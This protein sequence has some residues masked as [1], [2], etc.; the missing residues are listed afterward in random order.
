MARKKVVIVIMEGPSDEDALGV[1]FQRFFDRDTVRVKVIHGDITTEKQVNASNILSRV[2]EV[3]KQTL[4]EYKLNKSDLLRVIHLAD[5]D[6][7]FIP[8]ASIVCDTSCARPV[9]SATQIRSQ[10][11]DGIIRRNLQ[12]KANL[13]RLHTSPFIWGD[14]PYSIYYMSCNLDHVLYNRLNLTDDDK[15]KEALI[16][17]RSYRDDIP[18]FIEFIS[19][20]DF[21]VTDGYLSSWAFIKTDLHS[22]ERHTNLGICFL[23]NKPCEANEEKGENS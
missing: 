12:K 18:T 21:S 23:E 17:A 13:T 10:N 8:D 6:G 19:H 5:T 3:I 2:T 11:P 4:R 7:A 14:I 1:I 20:S 16:F 9:Y 15:E 22:L